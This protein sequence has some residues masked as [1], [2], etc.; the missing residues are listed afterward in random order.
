VAAQQGFF[1]A[2]F[3]DDAGLCG[4]FSGMR[5]TAS[6]LAIS[7]LSAAFGPVAKIPVT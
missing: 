6:V 2:C 7:S 5:R 4:S 1:A 3:E